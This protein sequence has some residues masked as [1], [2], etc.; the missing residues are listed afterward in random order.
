M[1]TTFMC[2]TFWEVPVSNILLFIFIPL[3]RSYW[4]VEDGPP[5]TKF[6]LD[7]LTHGA[8]Y[9]LEEC[10]KIYDVWVF[11]GRTEQDPKCLREQGK[12]ADLGFLW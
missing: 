11:L 5:A 9:T 1:L 8:T 4:I 3:L 6:G 2:V 7:F 12:E 10:E